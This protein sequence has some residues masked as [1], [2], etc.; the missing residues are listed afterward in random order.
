MRLPACHPGHPVTLVSAPQR[1][2]KADA[3]ARLASAT[4]PGVFSTVGQHESPMQP[5]APTDMHVFNNGHPSTLA[6]L[7]A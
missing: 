7:S 4:L 1:R 6:D 2:Q 5:A 3:R